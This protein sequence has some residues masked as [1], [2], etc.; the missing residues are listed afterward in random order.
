[1]H[2]PSTG[3]GTGWVGVDGVCFGVTGFGFGDGGC[4]RLNTSFYK[5][6]GP[7][8]GMT[9]FLTDS[10]RVFFCFGMA[11]LFLRDDGGRF[12][13]GPSTGSG[14]DIRVGAQGSGGAGWLVLGMAEGG[15]H[16]PSTELRDR[17]SGGLGVVGGAGWLFFVLDGGSCGLI[18][19]RRWRGG[20]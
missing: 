16:G 5:I 19:G 10:G 3:S 4:V 1:M 18:C 20:R 6:P 12:L 7:G 8:L 13:H 17:C 15:L 11:G 14:T 2:G 9:V